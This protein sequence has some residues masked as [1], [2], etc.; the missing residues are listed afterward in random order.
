MRITTSFIVNN[1]SINQLQSERTALAEKGNRSYLLGNLNFA[2]QKRTWV[3]Q[4]ALKVRHSYY[5]SKKGVA[6]LVGFEPTTRCLE[7][8]RSIH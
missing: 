8:S 7:G 4:K 5:R 6:S 2:A 3:F 1:I